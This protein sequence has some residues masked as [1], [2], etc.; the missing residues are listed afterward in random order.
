M[1]VVVLF[2]RGG[3][4]KMLQNNDL[5]ECSA[6]CGSMST[7]QEKGKGSYLDGEWVGL[8]LESRYYSIYAVQL[9]GIVVDILTL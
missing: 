3:G 4:Y 5:Q 2:L 8:Y 7:F 6:C 9:Y 1:F